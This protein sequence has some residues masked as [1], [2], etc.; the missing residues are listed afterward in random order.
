MVSRCGF[1]MHIPCDKVE[2]LCY[3]LSGHLDIIFS[4]VPVQDFIFVHFFFSVELPAFFSLV[5]SSL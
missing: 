1:H 5:Y 4:E 3:M 2:H